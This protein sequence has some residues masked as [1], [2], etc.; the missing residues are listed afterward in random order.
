[1]PDLR[2]AIHSSLTALAT[3]SLRD[4]AKSLLKTLGYESDRTIDLEGSKPQAFL[5]LIVS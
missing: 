2:P 5:D 4:A 1:M 3:G